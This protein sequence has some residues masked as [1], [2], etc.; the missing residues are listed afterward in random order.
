[1][2]PQHGDSRYCN[3]KCILFYALLLSI[4][5]FAF[6]CGYGITLQEPSVREQ[7]PIR[8]RAVS[9]SIP[10]EDPTEPWI[11]TLS[12]S[13]RLF[14][15]HNFLLPEECDQ[16][17]EIASKDVS[18]SLVVGAKG[19]AVESSVRTS[20]GVFLTDKFM[21]SSPLL[22]GVENR[23]A[24][25]TNLP[26]ENGEAFYILRYELGQ[27]YKPHT[28][29]FWNVPGDGTKYYSTEGNRIA[30]V[31]TYIQS[32][33]EGGATFFPAI[34]LR[35]PAKKG[36]A[37]LFWD[38]SPSNDG[39]PQ[40]LHGGDPVVKGVKWAMTKWIR[41]AKYWRYEDNLTQ[42]EKETIKNEDLLFEKERRTKMKH[43]SLKTK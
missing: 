32:P 14:L 31:L 16:I 33:D 2:W 42:E 40:A 12:W 15:Y 34:N 3:S 41:E 1:M 10:P 8:I 28:D 18:R 7:R 36:N 20:S 38:L 22:R 25:W 21:K 24:E 39:D 9:R 17:V 13:P 23:I 26:V 4:L 29:Y 35:V 30:T 6:I 11:E 5:V 37:V 19:E 43:S 27:E